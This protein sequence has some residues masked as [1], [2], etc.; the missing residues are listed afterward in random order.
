MLLILMFDLLSVLLSHVL[1]SLR[2]GGSSHT[3]KE[4]RL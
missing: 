3:G 1:R 4:K 2:V